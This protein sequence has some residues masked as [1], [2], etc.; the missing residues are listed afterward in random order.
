MGWPSRWVRWP[1]WWLSA[2]RHGARDAL[3][4]LLRRPEA[5][6]V[7]NASAKRPGPLSA[8]S[9]SLLGCLV[10]GRGLVVWLAPVVSG[11]NR[12]HQHRDLLR[13][14]PDRFPR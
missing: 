4:E 7:E 11:S 3:L 14:Q 12:S 9:K 6:R 1:D 5:E 8:R 13:Q 2:D 10:I